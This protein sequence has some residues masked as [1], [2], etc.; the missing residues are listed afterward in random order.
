MWFKERENSENNGENTQ[1]TYSANAAATN[2]TEKSSNHTITQDQLQSVASRSGLDMD[3]TREQVLDA[4]RE[5]NELRSGMSFSCFHHISV[6]SRNIQ[7][8]SKL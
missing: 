5:N 8:T 2:T 3:Y 4:L 1:Q 6:S 7:D